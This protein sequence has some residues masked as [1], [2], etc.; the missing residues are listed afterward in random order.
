MEARKPKIGIT[1]SFYPNAE[2]PPL[3]QQSLGRDYVRSV[4][5]AGGLPVLIP[6]LGDEALTEAYAALIDGLMLPGGEDV[7]PK[8]Y[9]QEPAEKLGHTSEARDRTELAMVRHAAAL[10][11]PIF[12]ICRGMQVLNVAFGGDM[13]QDISTAFPAY[14]THFGDMQH[15][16]SPWH[17]A[18]LEPDSRMARVFGKVEIG[19][20]S[21]HH[22][23]LGRVAEGFRV[24]AWSPEGIVE[25]IEREDAPIWGVQFHPENMAQEDPAFLELFR[26]FVADCQRAE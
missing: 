7:C 18:A 3:G 23:A 22:Q 10:S 9:G 20:N 1:M 21:F 5:Q 24:T 8:F 17:K 16:P 25:A 4:I 2:N 11:K 19:V 6:V 12:G 15:R 13:I 14:P 26:S